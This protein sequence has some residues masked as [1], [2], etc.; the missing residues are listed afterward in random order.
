MKWF[1]VDKSHTKQPEEGT[2]R[3]WKPLL[4][5][6]GRHQCVYCAIHERQFGGFRNFHVEHYQPRKIFPEL[7]NSIS[8]L[9]YACGI[10]N[11]FKGSSWP[12]NPAEDHS[13]AAFPYPARI[14]Y[15]QIIT[16]QDDC[17]LKSSV[18]AG[19][20]LIERLYLNRPQLLQ[21]R[22][23]FKL[24]DRLWVLTRE[25]DALT[26]TQAASNAALNALVQELTE[27]MRLLIEANTIIPYSENDV[28]R[29]A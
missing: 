9:F 12:A 1:Q 14:D 22:R 25:V 21:L 10:C 16:I 5:E 3:T 28:S 8:N 24:L 27:A 29:T 6:E 23:F 19:Q 13:V 17:S 7:T 11:S 2:Y 26:K 20:F 15:S 4:S 18:R